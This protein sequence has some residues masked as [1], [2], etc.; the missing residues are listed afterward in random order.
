MAKALIGHLQQDRG[1]TARLAVENRRLT[2]LKAKLRQYG[3]VFLDVI[4]EHIAGVS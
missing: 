1:L 4:R 2:D 3:E